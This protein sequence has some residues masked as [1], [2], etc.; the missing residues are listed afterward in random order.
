MTFNEK[1]IKLR[2]LKGL[3]QDEFAAAVGVS[4]QAVYKWES[5]QSY[6]EVPKLIEMKKIF[7][8]SI[9]DL[10]EEKGLETDSISLSGLIAEAEKTGK[11]PLAD[12]TV[13][14]CHADCDDNVA[15]ISNLMRERF[16]VTDIRAEYI[17]PVIGSHTG[18]GTLGLFFIGEHR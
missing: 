9:Y 17:G 4:R 14:I 16:G 8:I 2:K 10:L 12:Q 3:T 13:L 1:L 7:E 15:F 6:P 11:Q 5:G 18:L